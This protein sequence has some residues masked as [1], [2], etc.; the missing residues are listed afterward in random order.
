MQIFA[1][2]PQPV[3]FFKWIQ[4]FSSKK[5]R[6]ILKYIKLIDWGC[7]DGEA[8]SFSFKKM[9]IKFVTIYLLLTCNWLDCKFSTNKKI[10]LF[11]CIFV[12][13]KNCFN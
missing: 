6:T 8:V 1:R 12:I 5:K 7:G 11:L 3:T 2:G 9:F 13:S 10:A 4:I